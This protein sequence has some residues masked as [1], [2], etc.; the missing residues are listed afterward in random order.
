MEITLA[1]LVVD[2]RVKDIPWEF[3][4]PVV[5]QKH[6]CLFNNLAFWTQQEKALL[7]QARNIFII[8]MIFLT[9][10][11]SHERKRNYRDHVNREL[12]S[13]ERIQIL[14]ID[15]KLP[16]LPPHSPLAI[17]WKNILATNTSAPSNLKIL[18]LVFNYH[19]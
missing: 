14:V 3:H 1:K 12:S 5:R 7:I 19:V 8:L 10:Y 6:F 16:H 2:R 17:S 4:I 15:F 13:G 11:I 18:S 9:V